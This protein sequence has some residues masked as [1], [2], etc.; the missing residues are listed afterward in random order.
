MQIQ[1]VDPPAY[2]PPYDRALCGALARRGLDVELVTSTFRY[3][4]VPPADGYRVV[5]AFYRLP[6]PFRLGGRAQTAWRLMQ[7]V[8]NMLSYRRRA[9]AADLVHYQ[10]LAAQVI[11][12]RLLPPSRPRVLTAHDIL[13]REPRPGA[14]AATKALVNSMDA[15]I[16]HS[17]HGARRLCDELEV[18]AENVN[19][20]HHGAFDYLTHLDA[21]ALPSDLAAVRRPVIL[22][23]GLV[24]PYKGVDVLLRAFE[25]VAGAE[26][27][28]VGMPKMPLGELYELADKATG[29]VRF[30]TRFVAE[31]EIPAYFRRADIVV[32][33][34]TEIDQSGV[35]YTA[36]AFGKAMILSSV[37]GFTEFANAHGAAR[38]VAPDDPQS[39]AAALSE[40]LE[41]SD[42]RSDLSQA[43]LQAAHGAYSWDRI[44]EQTAA[45]YK[46][47]AS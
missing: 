45:L 6:T 40:L 37:G 21:R 28:I 33:P 31:D 25:S 29:T 42:V 8:P 38:L 2:T 20:I 18:P 34:Y 14:L 12:R 5:D 22:F 7:H 11:D 1:I 15:V 16:A 27:W 30:V 36:L 26:L 47:L 4:S 44:A 10:W 35:L 39:L 41:D 9:A 23:F 17:D 3:G 13:P 24:R 19:V 32:L 43:A 46:R